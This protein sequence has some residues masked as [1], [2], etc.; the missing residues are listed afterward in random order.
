MSLSWLFGY[1]YWPD[2]ALCKLQIMV[3]S[4][5]KGVQTGA[6]NLPGKLSATA[7]A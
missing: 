4:C 3:P 5:K 6:P 1:L 2:Q 7:K